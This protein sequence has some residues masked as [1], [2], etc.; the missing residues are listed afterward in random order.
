MDFSKKKRDELLNSDL[1]PT[2]V[3]AGKA[4]EE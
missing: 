4:K 3:A 2:H 1:T